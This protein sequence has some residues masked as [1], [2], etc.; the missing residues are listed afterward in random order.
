MII[1]VIHLM[2]ENNAWKKLKQ[3]GII[4]TKSPNN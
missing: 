2:Y 4:F 1:V 3:I